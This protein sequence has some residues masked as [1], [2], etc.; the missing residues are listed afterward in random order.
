MSI[1]IDEAA[2]IHEAVVAG[3]CVSGTSSHRLGGHVVHFSAAIALQAQQPSSALEVS[4]MG[5]GE[6][7][8]NCSCADTMT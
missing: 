8:L 4:Q 6:N 5:F 1:E 3:L 7:C 2:L